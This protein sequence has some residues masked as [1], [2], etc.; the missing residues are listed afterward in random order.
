MIRKIAFAL[1]LLTAFN[2]GNAQITIKRNKPERE[3]WFHSLAFGMFINWSID[4]QTGPVIGHSLAGAS[5]DYLERYFS[6]L[7]QT[8]NPKG[9]DPEEWAELALLAGMKYMVFDAKHHNGFCMYDTK[10]TD[11]NII[12]TPFKRDALKETVAAFR[13]KG[14]AIGIYFSPDDFLWLYRHNIPIDRDR[15]ESI[16]GNNPELIDYLKKQLKELLTNYGRIDI[17]FIDGQAEKHEYV[18]KELA[19]YC[20]DID[21]DIVITRGGMETP[22]QLLPSGA[23]PGVW[24]ACYTMGRSWGYS[25]AHEKYRTGSELIN[26]LIETRVK[27][28]NFLLNIGPMSSGSV[29]PQ[30]E[31]LLREIALWQMANQE[32]IYDVE[33]FTIVKEKDVWI[34]KEKN[35]NNVF[36]YITD[37][38]WKYAERREFFIHSLKGNSKT[39]VS[40]LGHDGKV[41]EYEPTF[42]PTPWCIPTQKGLLLS[43]MPAQRLYQDNF[44]VNP[45]VIKVENVEFNP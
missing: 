44:W 43:V 39:K 5:D 38:T 22:E 25:P 15:T 12:N 31:I 45:L 36:L 14:I 10:T 21:P 20:W 4:V 30:E 1:C 42:D 35:K 2:A 41:V 6:R 23:L 19:S 29:A 11:F 3:Q 40:V 26:L 37:T 18:N 32:A 27:G 24:E 8:F 7:P 17:L 9:F 34:A 16:P 13:K 28:G 33:P